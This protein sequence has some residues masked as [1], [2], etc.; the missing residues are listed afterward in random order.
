MSLFDILR[1]PIGSPPTVEQIKALPSALFLLWIHMS[2]WKDHYGEDIDREYIAVWYQEHWT[3]I[4]E[5]PASFYR[6]HRDLET[7]RRL[8]RD[9]EDPP[10]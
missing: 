4:E 1:Y 10:E 8:I 5:E 6:D 9:Y 7:L 3:S 2:D